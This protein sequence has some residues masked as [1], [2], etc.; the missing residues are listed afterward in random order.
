MRGKCDILYFTTFPLTFDFGT[1]S[2]VL[3]ARGHLYLRRG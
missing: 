3:Q 1:Y 2:G